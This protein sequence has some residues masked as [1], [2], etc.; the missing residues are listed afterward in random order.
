MGSWLRVWPAFKIQATPAEPIPLHEAQWHTGWHHPS[1]SP[2]IWGNPEMTPAPGRKPQEGTMLGRSRGHAA[3]P[4]Q[5]DLPP[6]HQAGSWALGPSVGLEQEGPGPESTKARSL[7]TY[8]RGS[9]NPGIKAG[10]GSG[11]RRNLGQAHFLLRAS[12][13][14]SGARGLDQGI[15]ACSSS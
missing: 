11:R 2:E 5:E 9:I 7:G 8:Q 12:T 10:S 15:P 14:M 13:P 1:W 6:R 4:L 3:R